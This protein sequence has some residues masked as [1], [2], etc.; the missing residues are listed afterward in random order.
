MV[1]ICEKIVKDND[2]LKLLVT[3]EEIYEKV[4][5]YLTENFIISDFKILINANCESNTLF[6]SCENITNDYFHELKFTQNANTEIIFIIY[7]EEKDKFD[8]LNEKLLE[9]KLTLQAFS[10]TLYN[11]Y[12]E[13]SINKLSL[14]DSVTGLHNRLYLDNYADNILNIAN[15]EQKKIAFLKISIDQFKAVIDEFD[16]TIGDQ[17][18]KALANSLEHTVRSSDIVLKIDGDEFLI[19]LMNVIN[20]DNAI[21][22]AKKVI[23]NFSKVKVL[24][25]KETNQTLMKSICAGVSIFPDDASTIEEIIK[26]S[27]IAL[28]EAKNIGRSEVYKYTEEEANLID[29]F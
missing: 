28:Y 20:E 14:I 5:K 15:R 21:M 1:R 16:Y 18:L 23:N 8:M 6:T 24:V 19:I 26:Q 2:K 7:C 17:V 3:L 12:L 10:Q 25:N 4:E 11:K 13:I 22:I 29:F 27:D 9:L